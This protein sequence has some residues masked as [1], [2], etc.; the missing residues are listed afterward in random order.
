MISIERQPDLLP[1]TGDTT[2]RIV[3]RIVDDN[4]TEHWIASGISGPARSVLGRVSAD[5]SAWADPLDAWV[6]PRLE[7]LAREGRLGE[8]EPIP[9]YEPMRRYDVTSYDIDEKLERLIAEHRGA[10]R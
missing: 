7:H 3:Y 9:G 2:D 8:L 4:D 6:R 5:P 10:G 1:K